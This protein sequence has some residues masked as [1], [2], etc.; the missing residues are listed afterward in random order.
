L[1]RLTMV[2]DDNFYRFMRGEIVEYVLGQG[3]ARTAE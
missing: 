3:L 1:I 2:S